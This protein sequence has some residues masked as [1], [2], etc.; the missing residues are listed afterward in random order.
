MNSVKKALTPVLENQRYLL[1]RQ[2]VVNTAHLK[3]TSIEQQ[4]IKNRT[5]EI[6]NM[7]SE[8][9]QERP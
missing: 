7:L 9:N 4:D 1:Q 2:F 3:E 5:S 8:L 6:D